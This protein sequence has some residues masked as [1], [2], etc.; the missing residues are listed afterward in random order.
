LSL[1][2][3]IDIFLVDSIWFGSQAPAATGVGGGGQDITLHRGRTAEDDSR[4]GPQ[5]SSL[6]YLLL[7]FFVLIK[8]KASACFGTV[9][10][11]VQVPF[12]FP[13][14]KQWLDAAAAGAHIKTASVANKQPE[15]V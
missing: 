2:N 10:G 15:G 7:L 9:A 13:A 12:S 6:W 8:F 4:P 14:F 1:R 5:V 3:Y 11:G